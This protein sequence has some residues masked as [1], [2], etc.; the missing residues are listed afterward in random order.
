MISILLKLQ[1]LSS[2]SDSTQQT[3]NFGERMFC[4]CGFLYFIFSLFIYV[5]IL[6]STFSDNSQVKRHNSPLQIGS[7]ASVWEHSS[8][9]GPI[10]Y[11]HLQ[12][13]DLMGLNE[14]YLMREISRTSRSRYTSVKVSQNYITLSIFL[15]K[16]KLT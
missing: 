16:K 7:V 15:K 9:S 1:H 12:E 3:Q 4:F 14:L 13:F 10:F 8:R 6:I 11:I 2:Q 5:V